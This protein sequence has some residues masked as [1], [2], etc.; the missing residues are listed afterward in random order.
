MK[1]ILLC[2][3]AFAPLLA[4]NSDK[5]ND[6]KVREL[7][8]ELRVLELQKQIEHAKRNPIQRKDCFNCGENYMPG[9]VEPSGFMIGGGLVLGK[10]LV[11]SGYSSNGNGRPEQEYDWQTQWGGEV[12]LGY[13]WFF[14]PIFGLRLYT[15]Y[16][17]LFINR[18][19]PTTTH[20]F[21][22]NFDLMF[23]FNKSQTLRVGL[24]LG[25]HL[26]GGVV[27]YKYSK[28]CERGYGGYELC[29]S[30]PSFTIGGNLGLRFVIYDNHAVEPTFQP[31]MDFVNGLQMLG[32]VRYVYTF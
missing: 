5:S 8:Q 27:K 6:E 16:Q 18:V 4:Q 17:I 19:F 26:G 28:F 1:I 14:G 20:N 12:L 24:L 22:G 13:K 11:F 10:S 2:L 23:N 31:K 7:E 15:D 21:S 25:V 3:L 9:E 29:D 30:E 32:L